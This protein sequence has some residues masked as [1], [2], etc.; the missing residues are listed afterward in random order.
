MRRNAKPTPPG[1]ERG[2]FIACGPGASSKPARGIVTRPFACRRLEIVVHRTS[3]ARKTGLG[4]RGAVRPVTGDWAGFFTANS[5][6][7]SEEGVG[8]A[9]LR[10][11]K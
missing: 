5:E 7:I 10:T 3:A 6:A 11:A 9:S 4:V 8:A 2:G 1:I